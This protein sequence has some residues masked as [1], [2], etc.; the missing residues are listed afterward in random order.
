MIRLA[1]QNGGHYFF[2]GKQFE[3][4]D[5]LICFN[6]VSIPSSEILLGHFQ[7]GHPKFSILKKN[8]YHT[9][10]WIK[11]FPIF[12]VNFVQ[13]LNIVVVFLTHNHILNQNHLTWF[14]VMHG[15]PQKVEF[16]SRKPWFITFIDDDNRSLGFSC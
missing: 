8:C 9:C 15:V 2:D 10:S 11:M 14:T 3:G 16:F 4:Q 5:Q 6:S 13:W 7:L 12:N 1:K